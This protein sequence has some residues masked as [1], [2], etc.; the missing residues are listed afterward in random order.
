MDWGWTTVGSNF[1]EWYEIHVT[2]V[3]LDIVQCSCHFSFIIPCVSSCSKSWGTLR[4]ETIQY[5]IMWQL[6]ENTGW[7]FRS[8][9]NL[10]LWSM[11]D[12]S[13]G[14]RVNWNRS[15]LTVRCPKK[16]MIWE[17]KWWCC[18]DSVGTI[19]FL[20][21]AVGYTNYC[22]AFF[23]FLERGWTQESPREDSNKEALPA[24]G[25]K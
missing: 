19:S 21:V 9:S 1:H 10:W 5:S 8:I 15:P 6:L 7:K 24:P 18:H 25:D 17:K 12:M 23:I 16:G 3:C 4:A 22:V 13:Y 20:C 11:D 14:K 2:N